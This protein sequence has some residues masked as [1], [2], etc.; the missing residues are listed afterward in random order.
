[1][2]EYTINIFNTNFI[3]LT[4]SGNGGAISI[5]ND[6]SNLYTVSSIFNYCYLPYSSQTEGGAIYC[7]SK[8]GHFEGSKLCASHCAA[9][10]RSFIYCLSTYESKEKTTF[11]LSSY[12]CCANSSSLGNNRVVELK[13]DKAESSYVNATCNTVYYHVVIGFDTKSSSFSSFS[14]YENNTV[15]ALF[16][17]WNTI[18][19]LHLTT[20]VFLESKRLTSSFSLIHS[21]CP[22]G[23]TV[24]VSNCSF[25]NNYSPLFE[26]RNNNI[27]VR[28]CICDKFTVSGT[29]QTTNIQTTGSFSFIIF[30]H[31]CIEFKKY[32]MCSN[33]LCRNEYS[34]IFMF[35]IILIS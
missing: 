26:Y 8:Y 29:I 10:L 4:N 16:C 25:F 17:F 2:K 27:E 24:L 33:A 18:G 5:S 9:Y 35:L 7:S 11:K 21:N 19:E 31:S 12:H 22:N 23:K 15:D 34:N 30:S 28:D 3:Y 13:S 14:I 1:M 20:S 32:I 6:Y